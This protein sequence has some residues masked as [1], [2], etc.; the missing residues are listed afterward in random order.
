MTDKEKLI[1]KKLGYTSY[2]MYQ[3]IK[4]HPT[5]QN[6]EMQ[7]EL[8]FSKESTYRSFKKLKT[9]GIISIEG[10]CYNRVFTINNEL[11]WKI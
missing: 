11:D 7:W 1:I 6:K 9:C 10:N 5:F 3:Y 8:G 4:H 2:V